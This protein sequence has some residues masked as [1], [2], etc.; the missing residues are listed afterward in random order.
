MVWSG[1]PAAQAGTSHRMAN[2]TRRSEGAKPCRSTG[3]PGSY[4]GFFWQQRGKKPADSSPSQK[5]WRQKFKQAVYKCRRNI[6]AHI[7]YKLR[8]IHPNPGPRDKTMEGKAR[9]RE[10]RKNRREDKRKLKQNKAKEN[11]FDVVTWNVQRMPLD[12]FNKRKAKAVAEFARKNKW[13]AVLLSEIKAKTGGIYWLGQDELLT[14]IIFTERAAILL[15]DQLLQLWCETGQVTVRNERTISIKIKDLTLT[16]TYMPVWSGNNEQEIETAK[17]NLKSHVEKVKKEEILLVGGDFNAHV[18]QGEERP[19]VCGRFGLRSSNRQGEELIDFCQENNLAYVNSYFQ[20]K[21]RGTWFNPALRRW[22][23]LDGFLVKSNQ[24]HKLVQK[25]NVINEISL[26]DHKPVRVRIILNKPKKHDR[27]KKRSPKIRWER[28]RDAEVANNY[29]EKINNIVEEAEDANNNQNI[30]DRWKEITDTTI[31]AATE[32]CG[33][34]E[35][36]IEN[37][38]MIDK[39]DEVKRL[40]ER[41]T[42][43]VNRRNELMER[44]RQT[45]DDERLQIETDLNNAK[46]DLKEARSTLQRQTRQW[47]KDW[48][49]N[50]IKEC[51]E[52]GEKGDSGTLYKT[53]K[54]LGTRGFKTAPETTTITKEEFKD[55]FQ[56]ISKDRFENDPE[57]IFEAVDKMEDLRDNEEARR[58]AIQLDET[59]SRE[60]ILTQMKKM[61]NSAPGKDGVRLIYILQGGPIILEKIV[62]LIQFMFENDA[63]E[64]E[65]ELKEGQV[66]PLFKKGDRNNTNNF[67][68]V[69]L[70]AMGSRI[71][72]RIAADRLR[73]WSEQLN[74]LD[75]DQSGFRKE[76]STADVTQIMYRILEDTEDLLKRLEAKG[77]TLPEDSRPSARLLDLRK[78]YPRVN[79]PALWRILEKCGMGPKFLRVLK[80]LHETTFYRIKSREGESEE[81]T[82]ERGLREGGPSSPQLFNIYHQVVMRQGEKARKRKAE[83]TNLDYGLNYNWVPGSCFPSQGRWEKGNSEAKRIKISQGLFADDTTVI[84]K[85]KEL[86]Q[87]VREI[88]KVMDKFE[89]R[90]NEDKEEFL[91]FGKVESR[92]TRVLGCLMGWKED[93]NNRIKKAGSAWVKV[94]HRL[95]GTKISKSLQ[96]R[97]IEACIESTM[98]FDC[99]TR[100]WQVGEILKMQRTMDKKYRYIWSNKTKPPL[101]QMQ[102]EGKNMQDIRNELKIKTLRYKIEKRVL[103]RIGHVMRMDDSRMTKA[104]ILGWLEDLEAVEKVPGKKRKTVLYWKRIIKEAGMDWT[105]IGQITKDRKIW[106]KAVKT[107]MKY[108]EK[109]ERRKG[110][111]IP[112]MSG[113][114]NQDPGTVLSLVCSYEGCG[115]ICL[116]KTGVTN[117]ER[118]I[119]EIS[120][121]KKMFKCDKCDKNFL[122]KSNLTTHKKVCTGLVARNV[123]NKKC[124]KCLKEVSASNFARHRKKCAPEENRGQNTT[125]AKPKVPCDRCGAQI[126]SNNLARHK[127]LNCL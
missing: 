118:R 63:I 72:G 68:G 2:R 33:I 91:D 107:R 18:G 101:F 53:L 76:R 126:S 23:E 62:D 17:E 10:R 103:Q 46:T 7:T 121:Q 30:N 71:L 26:S 9:R 15:R 88:K 65:V 100:T 110:K 82:T 123:N 27:P 44:S 20:N 104:V 115:R 124:D 5:T 13:D 50:I 36:K 109:W 45:A 73:I 70:L 12:N 77:E 37:P 89:E 93:T 117:H 52:A 40:R 97:I 90:N 125:T 84:G 56:R 8:T 114:R 75:D 78:A 108:L 49:E 57:I 98:L 16:A 99:H 60:E 102:E 113:H 74:L 111:K 39:E 64:W 116:T 43:C 42:V 59:P 24:R 81:W 79:K 66:I 28:L 32:V 69:V 41:I 51:Q 67:R 1:L 119:H 83:E 105:K 61:K 127:R 87:G 96:A 31:K 3:Q 47:E 19:D 54:K 38:W 86:E 6:V 21:R 80:D 94:K 58:W 48:W 35:K 29:R 92:K 14:A 122:G 112:E 22:Y 11:V 25:L 4:W 55:H 34:E 120:S 106:R 85:K 95:K